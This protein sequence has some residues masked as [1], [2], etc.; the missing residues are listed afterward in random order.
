ML[1]DARTPNVAIHRVAFPG[2]MA[3]ASSSS[4]RHV[5]SIR[6]TDVVADWSYL[7][8]REPGVVAVV[9]RDA[10]HS[11]I[12]E[13][14]AARDRRATRIRARPRR[15]RGRAD[16]VQ[17]GRSQQRGQ[18]ASE[19]LRRLLAGQSARSRHFVHQRLYPSMRLATIGF[20]RGHRFEQHDPEAL[21]PRAGEHTTS[22][23]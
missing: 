23:A 21:P 14:E 3:A 4:S 5:R 12:D 18:L 6:L 20:A 17:V 13:L 15:R 16:A 22:A 19:R 10:H 9:P 11:P 7:I 1:V 2:V 8:E